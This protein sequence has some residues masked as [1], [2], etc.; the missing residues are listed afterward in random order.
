MKLEKNVGVLDAVLRVG[1]GLVLIYLGLASDMINDSIAS[2]L[3]GIF[4][5]VIFASGVFRNCPM[6]TLIGFNS[7][8]HP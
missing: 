7:C 6:Y 1:I 3:L 5:I 8:N 2:T 4:G